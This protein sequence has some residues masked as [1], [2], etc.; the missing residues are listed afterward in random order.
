MELQF[1]NVTKDYGNVHAVEH[2]THSMG[3]GVYGLLGVNGAGKT[4]LMRM[5]CTAIT[6]TSGEIL[7]NGKNIFSL[8]A[9]YRE[10]LG[11][12]PQ[13][14]GFY[15]DLSV[16]DYMLYIASIKGIRPIM[17]KK[18][19][20]KLLEQVGLAEKRKSKMR[21][22][23][24]GM[25]RRVGIAQA[26]LNNPRIL[27]LDEPTAG[28]D[29]MGVSELMHL[30]RDICENEGT[31]IIMSTHDIDVVPIYSDY[32]YVINHGKLLT[33]GTPEEVFSNPT[34]LR[35]HNLRLP[36]IAHLLEI[37]NKCDKLNVD[38]SKATIGKAREE[39]LNLIR[40]K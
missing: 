8:G 35:E 4:T 17:A 10:I 12:L 23:S 5:I 24:G 9:S 33:D 39:I 14:Y 22:L 6:P 27:V 34:L 15:P 28:L 26:M 18:R 20:L 32:V 2:V 1:K 16:Y 29:P 36:R 40:G 30:L 37:L 7:W 25:I 19:A 13:S 38:F 3:K 21:T 11:Y 31:T